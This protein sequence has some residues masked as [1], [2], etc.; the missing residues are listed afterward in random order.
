MQASR[1]YIRIFFSRYYGATVVHDECLVKRCA[2]CVLD[3][4]NQTRA[5]LQ[6]LVAHRVHERVQIDLMDLGS[7]PDAITFGPKNPMGWVLDAAYLKG[8]CK[9]F[10]RPKM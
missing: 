6:S 9:T 10:Q 3:T 5:P 4:E 8:A 7:Y 2:V 1:P